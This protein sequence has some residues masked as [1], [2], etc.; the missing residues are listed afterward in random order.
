MK[1]QQGITHFV[2]GGG[3]RMLVSTRPDRETARTVKAHHF[4][5]A[6]VYADRMDFQVISELGFLIDQGSIAK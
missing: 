1:P 3:G 4:L 2:T 5:H 6:Q